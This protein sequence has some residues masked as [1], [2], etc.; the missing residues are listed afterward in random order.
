MAAE[1]AVPVPQTAAAPAVERRQWAGWSWL[2]TV[3]H[4]QIG[5]LYTLT[6]LGF[7]LIGGLE[8]L[9]VRTQLISPLNSFLHPDVYNQMFTMHATTMI[10]L[11]IMPLNVG[12]GNYIVPL[13]IGA[14]DMA[15]PRLNAFSYWS[16]LLGGIVLYSAWFAAG[17]PADTGWYLYPPYAAYSDS[18]VDLT[19]LG[20]HLL[21]VSSIAGAINFVATVQT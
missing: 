12:I 13:M 2:A 5:I 19:I 1:V 17:G 18:S 15:Y 20:L 6:A 11:A 10:F 7:F 8:A 16:F 14:G 4:K 21:A 3:D 9:L